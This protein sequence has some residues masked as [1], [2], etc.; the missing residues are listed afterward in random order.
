MHKH[1]SLTFGQPDKVAPVGGGGGEGGLKPSTDCY[2]LLEKPVYA[3]MHW[4]SNAQVLKYLI[5]MVH[6]L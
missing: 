4:P 2:I 5:G 1:I 6:K 3:A